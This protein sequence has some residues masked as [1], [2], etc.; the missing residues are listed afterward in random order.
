LSTAA[1]CARVTDTLIDNQHLCTVC[2][3]R[4]SCY[5]TSHP[6]RMQASPVPA[7]STHPTTPLIL[8]PLLTLPPS[9]VLMASMTVTTLT[10]HSASSRKC[11]TIV[12][13]HPHQLLILLLLMMLMLIIT[14]PSTA[15]TYH[16]LPD[17]FTMSGLTVCLD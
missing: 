13:H 15:P 17:I 4:S 7:P 16:D 12:S 3:F 10:P 14:S 1:T 6:T 2:S 5:R 9:C 11:S 8:L